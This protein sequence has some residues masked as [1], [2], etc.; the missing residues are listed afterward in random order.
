MAKT[1]SVPE[2]LFDSAYAA[3]CFAYRYSTQQYSPT[4]MARLMR[5]AIGSGKGLVGLDGAAQSGFIRREVEQLRMYERF[6]VIARFALDEKERC[7]AMLAL[8]CPAAASLG[9]G[10]HNRRMVDNLVQKYFGQR[11]YLKDLAAEYG[12]HADTMTQRWSCIKRLLRE[13]ENRGID[14]MEVRLQAMGLVPS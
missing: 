9:T 8:T 4:P 13:V 10:V 7:L 14:Q 5:G 1:A 2:P 12:V 6:A 11:C 3:L